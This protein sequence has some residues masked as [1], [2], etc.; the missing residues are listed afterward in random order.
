MR[1][2][3][4][5]LLGLLVS[6]ACTARPSI[7]GLPNT[8]VRSQ[9][10]TPQRRLTKN[11]RKASNC[12]VGKAHCIPCNVR[13]QSAVSCVSSHLTTRKRGSFLPVSRVSAI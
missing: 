8:L 1:K 9:W 2:R 13:R 12:D 11:L 6:S 4:I 3:S 5:V 7:S 10:S